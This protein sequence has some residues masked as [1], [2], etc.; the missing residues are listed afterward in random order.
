M[1]LPVLFRNHFQL[2]YVVRNLD[3]AIET[4]RKRFGVKEWEVRHLPASAPG[5]ALGNAWVDGTLIELVDLWPGGDTFYHA[6]IPDDEA[7]LRLHHLGY[8]IDSEAEWRDAIAQMETAGFKPVLVGGAPGVMDWY[9]AD[10]VAMLGHYT[11][12]MRYTSEAGKGFWADVPR[13]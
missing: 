1:T 9:Y 13:N 10:T 12:L 7:G 3:A 8:L 2:G 5:R 11:E 6:W 4:M